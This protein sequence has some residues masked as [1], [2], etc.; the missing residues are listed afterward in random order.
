MEATIETASKHP[1]V[2]SPQLDS[3][4]PSDV[5]VAD[6]FNLAML[7]L[8][9]MG[10]IQHCSQ[11]C[12]QVFGYRQYELEGRH[13]STLLPELADT[14]LVLEDRINSRL[15]FFCHCA[16]PFQAR[17]RDGN[18]FTSELFIN[19]LCSQNVVVLV[20]SLDV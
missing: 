7:A 12:E 11:T 17:R 3:R 20:R 4:S 9:D 15:A 18:I 16:I 1:Q 8:N 14:E 5:P 19:R 13:V 10:I 2:K 6:P